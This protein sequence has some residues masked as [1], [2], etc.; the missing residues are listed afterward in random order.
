M[1]PIKVRC[2]KCGRYL[3]ETT[4]TLIAENIKCGGCKEKVNIKVVF[5]DSNIEDIRHKF[6]KSDKIEA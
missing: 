3:C 6:A 4:K 1:Q 5:P 2:P